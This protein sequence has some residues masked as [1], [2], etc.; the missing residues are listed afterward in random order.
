M[1]HY[2]LLA[3]YDSLLTTRYLRL[4]TDSQR[5]TDYLLP[6]PHYPIASLPHCLIVAVATHC[7]MVTTYHSPLYYILHTTDYLSLLIIGAMADTLSVLLWVPADIISQRLQLVGAAES[8]I[9]YPIPS[10]PI[11]SHPNPSHTTPHHTSPRHATP[12][13]TTPHHTTPHHTKPHRTTP[14]HTT[15]HRTP[16]R[17]D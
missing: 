17:Y 13:H 6:Q 14:H 4:T 5:T 10:H 9:V 11:P 16:L 2:S 7:L 1:T 8:A 12:R 15:P 3:T